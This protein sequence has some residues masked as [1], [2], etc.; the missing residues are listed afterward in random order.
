MNSTLHI[1]PPAPV[2]T[3]RRGAF[4]DLD[5]TLIPGSSLF[6]LAR[7]LHRRDLFGTADILRFASQQLIYRAGKVETAG[8]VS[9]SRVA[10]LEFVRGRR[11][12]DL[13]ALAREICDEEIL[14][15]VYPHMARL[16]EAHRTA[17]DVTF[18]ATAAPVELAAIL[19]DALGM[20]G[21]VGTEAEVDDG[22]RYSGTLHG[23]VLHGSAKAIAVAAAAAAWGVDLASSVAYSDSIN[24][25]P[26]L[27]LVGDAA[28]VNPDRKLR[29]VASARGWPVHDVRQ[30]RR[31][32]R[33]ATTRSAPRSPVSGR[34][35]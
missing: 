11:R 14:P 7:G 33:R 17:G 16:V 19:A 9:T 28:V 2:P 6:L 13:Q 4:F 30:R 24:D 20:T 35:S 18:L 32:R 10:A 15:N 8:A 26:L 31:R 1:S 22:E 34:R 23:P 12:A 21:A 3:G 29:A 27:E 25:L 5:R